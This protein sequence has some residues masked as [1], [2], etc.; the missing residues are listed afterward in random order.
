MSTGTVDHLASVT[1]LNFE[2][3]PDA[4]QHSPEVRRFWS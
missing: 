1:D 3:Y 2:G 4:M